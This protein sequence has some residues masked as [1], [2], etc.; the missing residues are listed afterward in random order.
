M[1]KIYLFS[2]FSLFSQ[3]PELLFSRVKI[4]KSRNENISDKDILNLAPHYPPL[5]D[6]ISAPILSIKSIRNIYFREL[7]KKR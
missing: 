3:L 6:E 7:N 4:Q 2:Y 5:L 1:L